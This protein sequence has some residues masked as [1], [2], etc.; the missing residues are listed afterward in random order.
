MNTQA[1]HLPRV[2]T[3]RSDGSTKRAFRLACSVVPPLALVSLLVGSGWFWI[4]DLLMS[5]YWLFW[6]VSVA[7]LLVLC[8]PRRRLV[9][10]LSLLVVI[11][12]IWPMIASRSLW[13]PTDIG[14]DGKGDVSVL[15][16]NSDMGNKARGR[17]LP[18]VLDQH[19]DVAVILEPVWDF[20]ASV[21][22]F[23]EVD[24]YYPSWLERTTEQGN[25]RILVLSRWPMTRFEEEPLANIDG[26]V[27]LVHRP[28]EAG[29][30]FV[31]IATHPHSP[32]D[33][34]RWAYGNDS[35]R[36]I[37]D[38]IDQLIAEGYRVVLG[39]DLN[40]PPG[41]IRDRILR[42]SAGAVRGKPL[43]GQWGTFPASWSVGRIAIDD[44]WCPPG[45]R[46]RSWRTVRGPGSD[47][48]AVRAVISLTDTAIEPADR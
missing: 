30:E 24:G 33:P 10:V 34:G 14:V 5:G 11:G 32:R 15:V 47:H 19:T 42:R 29:G 27:C 17:V 18:F 21:T 2:P 44:V 22:K 1:G 43:F 31:V 45:T 48:R 37:A 46:V 16:F 6:F 8:I 3:P 39:A 40:A 41:S 38:R 23:H 35:L 20:Y 36:R 13:I 28:A 12:C 7:V 4:L 9:P 26:L 25:A